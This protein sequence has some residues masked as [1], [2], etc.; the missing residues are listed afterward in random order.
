MASQNQEKSTLIRKYPVNYY[1]VYS[2]HSKALIYTG[3]KEECERYIR[4]KELE[5]CEVWH[6]HDIEIHSKPV[7]IQNQE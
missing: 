7:Y 5:G 1:V 3:K 6:F 2:P 4:D